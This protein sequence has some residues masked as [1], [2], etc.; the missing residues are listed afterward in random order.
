M[1]AFWETKEWQEAKSQT[2]KTDK[3][4][5]RSEYLRT[6]GAKEYSEEKY[7]RYM[8]VMLTKE[9]GDPKNEDL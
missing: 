4:L 6:I 9:K 8:A 3:L 1:K 2:S 5:S 7:Q